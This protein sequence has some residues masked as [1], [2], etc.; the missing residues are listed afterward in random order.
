MIPIKMLDELKTFVDA[1]VRP[2]QNVH[3]TQMFLYKSA[4]PSGAGSMREVSRQCDN[5]MMIGPEE[6]E[7]FF[8][9]KRKPSFRQIL[10]KH[11]DEKNEKD[12]DIYKKAGVDRRVFSK[13]RSNRDYHPSKHTAIALALALELNLPEAEALLRTA[14]FTL[15]DSE[16][17]DLIIIFCIERRIYNIMDV[18]TALSYLGCA[19]LGMEK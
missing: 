2:S 13:I 18:N 5:I 3:E 6:L 16:T 7:D 17:F 15:S 10:F 12:S 8:N 19:M 14:G 1:H 9:E 11:I 4:P